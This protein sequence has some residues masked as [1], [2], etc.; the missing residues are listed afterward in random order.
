M[1]MR[2]ILSLSTLALLLTGSVTPVLAKDPTPLVAPSSETILAGSVA[3]GALQCTDTYRFRCPAR[4][5][6]ATA[7]VT[8]NDGLG[9]NISITL[10]AVTPVSMRGDSRQTFT[11]ATG[12]G[13]D[14]AVSLTRPT[15]GA[16]DMY[17]MVANFTNIEVA[18]LLDLI[19]LDNN[20]DF[21]TPT[22]T[23]LQ[24]E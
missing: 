19:C 5:R 18:Y 24:D 7:V 15:P 6:I 21:L 1:K 13:S 11:P 22:I 3:C 20:L 14:D 9:D 12:Q 23:L 2:K 10:L 17:V 8:D 16:M 4:S